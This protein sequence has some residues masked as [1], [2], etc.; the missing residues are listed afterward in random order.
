MPQS[1]SHTPSF[2]TPSPTPFPHTSPIPLS[3]YP[4][5]L[6]TT[7]APTPHSPGGSLDLS[8]SMATMLMIMT[9]IGQS[10]MSCSF[11][12]KAMRHTHWVSSLERSG[13]WRRISRFTFCWNLFMS[14]SCWERRG[15]NGEVRLVECGLW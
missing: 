5:S 3:T 12:T 4:P 10:K 9:Q 6:P 1:T 2:P 14:K 15:G 13:Y 8:M 11:L 7:P